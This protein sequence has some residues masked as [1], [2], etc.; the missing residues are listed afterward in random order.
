MDNAPQPET[1]Q[2]RT[3][4]SIQA[5]AAPPPP[6]GSP[7]A[8]KPPHRTFRPSHRATFIGL[9]AVMA[10]LAIN[11]AVFTVLL[12]KQ[13]AN[14]TLAKGQVSISTAD[15]NKLGINRNSVGDTGILLTVAP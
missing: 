9:G 3:A 2:R 8:K 13:A 15:L 10:I 1:L 11:A 5:A 4:D 6:S 14:D 12:K 7:V